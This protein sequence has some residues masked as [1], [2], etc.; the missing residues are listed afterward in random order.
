MDLARARFLASARGQAA[1]ASLRPGLA[2]EPLNRLS[3]I[4]RRDYP[5]DEA[6]ALGEQ[7]TLRARAASRFNGLKDFVFTTDGLAMMT[8]PLVAARRAGRLAC[9]GLPV[10]D[11]TCGIGGDLAACVSA[12]IPSVGIE[13]DRAT[14][15]V[16]ASNVPGAQVVLGDASRPPIDLGKV[17]VVIDPSRRSDA[18]RRFDPAAFSPTWDVAVALLIGARAGALKGP[19]GI[20]HHHLPPS[21]EWE[22]VQLGRSLREVAVWAG[23]GAE[24]GLRRAVL[25]PSGTTIDSNEPEAAAQVSQPSSFLFDPEACVTNAGLVRHLAARLGASLMDSRVGYLTAAAPAFN[26]LAA[27][28]EVLDQAPFSVSALKKSLRA[29]GWKPDEIRRR[30]FPVEPDELRRLLGVTEGEPVTLICTTLGG[31]RTVFVARRLTK[32][33]TTDIA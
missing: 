8:H 14:G 2:E 12:G 31:K 27:T 29:R 15:V 10:A 1:L 22:W 28:F 13:S 16:A 4:L 21:A 23:A 9:A 33:A 7:V 6:A 17:A 30:A 25:L 18:G 24:A 11:L 32:A 19:P 20:D 3:D 26:D 5:P